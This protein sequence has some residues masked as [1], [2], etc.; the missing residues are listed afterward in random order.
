MIKFR[1]LAN[2]VILPSPDL[3]DIDRIKPFVRQQRSYAGNTHSV[4][5]TTHD[6]EFSLEFSHL[7][8]INQNEL[9]S[10]IEVVGGSIFT[11]TD[12]EDTEHNVQFL[13]NEFS[14]N[15]KAEVKENEEAETITIN[16]LRH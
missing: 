1:Y 4:Y 2:E 6:L 12:Y 8:I 13:D 11:Y 9:I 3:S 16:L 10:F 7:N 14:F 5:K 15:T